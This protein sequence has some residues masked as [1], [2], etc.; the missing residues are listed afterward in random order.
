MSDSFSFGNVTGPVNAGSGN[1]N[2]GSGAQNVAGRDLHI[3][4]RVDADPDAAADLAALRELLTGLPLTAGQRAGATA[5]LDALADTSDRAEAGGRLESF[6]VQVKRAGALAGAGS[7][8][9][10]AV[11]RLAAWIGPLAAGAAALLT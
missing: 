11:T 4:H 2:V 7:S 8:F 6:V 5:E 1:M 10:G 3:G 9:V